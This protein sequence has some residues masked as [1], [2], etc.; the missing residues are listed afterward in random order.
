MRAIKKHASRGECL[1]VLVINKTNYICLGLSSDLTPPIIITGINDNRIRFLT[2][3]RNYSDN[4]YFNS[5]R[6]VTATVPTTPSRTPT[7]TPNYVATSI[8][9]PSVPPPPTLP[10]PP[11]PLT[12]NITPSVTPT[13]KPNPYPLLD[14][15]GIDTDLDKN[16]IT[17]SN[18]MSELVTLHKKS[19]KKLEFTYR[20]GKP[21]LLVPIPNAKNFIT[22][23]K[24]KRREKWIQSI[25]DFINSEDLPTDSDDAC[26]WML[27]CI[28][29]KRPKIFVQVAQDVGIHVIN[30]M[31]D[32]EAAAMWVEANILYRA[33]RVILRHLHAKFNFRVQVPFTQISLLSIP[34][35][36][37]SFGHFEFKKKG[38]EMKVGEKVKYWTISP[39]EFIQTDFS[40]LLSCKKE[41][42]NTTFKYKLSIWVLWC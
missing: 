42:H 26:C 5:D 39:E 35:L 1:K 40:R 18:L 31:T 24:N 25:F 32:V 8:P 2:S 37:P 21:G 38:E 36:T 15:L 11:P 27:K 12:T 13:R 10:P 34:S 33:A 7:H 6:N 9:S 23:E 4:N 14:S 3:D 19:N 20:N 41:Y 28:Y 29:K 22:Y 17:I 30:K 16:A